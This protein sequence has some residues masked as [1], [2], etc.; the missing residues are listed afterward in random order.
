[1][2]SSS[3]TPWSRSTGSE[4]YGIVS[5]VLPLTACKAT[6]STKNPES[7]LK[8]TPVSNSLMQIFSPALA[9]LTWSSVVHTLAVVR[10][11]DTGLM[12]IGVNTSP[13]LTETFGYPAVQLGRKAIRWNVSKPCPTTSNSVAL[14]W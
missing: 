4:P 2:S 13:S 3:P 9:S 11:E 6:T 10:S 8:S 7:T 5:V 14:P 12:Y 1:M